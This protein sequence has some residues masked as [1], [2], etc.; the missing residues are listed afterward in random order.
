MSL[1]TAWSQT[2][3]A[4]KLQTRKSYIAF[5]AFVMHDALYTWVG[6]SALTWR[7]CPESELDSQTDRQPASWRQHVNSGFILCERVTSRLVTRLGPLSARLPACLCSLM[8]TTAL[9]IAT[10]T[11]TALSFTLFRSVQNFLTATADQFA[12]VT[13]I[14]CRLLPPLTLWLI[15]EMSHHWNNRNTRCVNFQNKLIFAPT[16]SAYLSLKFDNNFLDF[17]SKN[18]HWPKLKHTERVKQ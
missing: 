11:N 17:C 13:F 6:Q 14:L 1:L 9:F 7:T 12:N 3:N 15:T 2:A 10:E 8:L 5:Y 4:I 16:W 18:F